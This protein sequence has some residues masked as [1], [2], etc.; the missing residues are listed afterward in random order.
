VI[1]K[2]ILKFSSKCQHSFHLFYINSKIHFVLSL[3]ILK[4]VLSRS[5]S[6]QAYRKYREGENL[7]V[8]FEP[9][10]WLSKPGK[11]VLLK[12]KKSATKRNSTLQFS[13]RKHSLSTASLAPG[14][15][16]GKKKDELCLGSLRLLL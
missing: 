9:Y 16:T 5:L 2:I 1:I 11:G 12:K 14:K 15:G 8:L 4:A 7:D 6:V 10:D 3:Q 13:V